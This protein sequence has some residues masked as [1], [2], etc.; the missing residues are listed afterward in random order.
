MLFWTYPADRE[1]LKATRQPCDLLTLLPRPTH[2][3][4]LLGSDSNLCLYFV[5]P[6]K[7][8]EASDDESHEAHEGSWLLKAGR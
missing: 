4:N 2:Y 6:L 7:D 3:C 1:L 8:R 5:P